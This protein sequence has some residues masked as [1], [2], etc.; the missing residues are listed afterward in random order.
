MLIARRNA[1]S[2]SFEPSSGRDY[3]GVSVIHLQL[4]PMAAASFHIKEDGERGRGGEKLLFKGLFHLGANLAY[5]VLSDLILQHTSR[6]IREGP[7]RDSS[8]C[9]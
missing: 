4:R 7:A 6:A 3:G 1:L 2:E 9:P 8:T 5:T